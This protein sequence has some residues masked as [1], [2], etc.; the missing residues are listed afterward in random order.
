MPNMPP[1]VPPERTPI[2]DDQEDYLAAITSGSR[3]DQVRYA[4]NRLQR[5]TVEQLQQAGEYVQREASGAKTEP[6][7]VGC[8]RLLVILKQGR[9]DIRTGLLQLASEPALLATAKEQACTS[10]QS[11]PKVMPVVVNVCGAAQEFA[12]EQASRAK[13]A[14]DAADAARDRTAEATLRIQDERKAQQI[15]DDMRNAA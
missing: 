8:I 6:P 13:R 9:M 1:R 3:I 14:T 10:L 4:Q 7:L 2:S 12:Q 5:I 15:R 11:F